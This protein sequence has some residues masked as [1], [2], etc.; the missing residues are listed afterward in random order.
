MNATKE[1]NH[2]TDLVHTQP[3]CRAVYV[4]IFAVMQLVYEVL[5]RFLDLPDFQPNIA[6]KYIHQ[7]FIV[8]VVSRE[9][10][11]WESSY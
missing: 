3:G 7:R 9:L 8:Q 11:L 4:W 2:L 5:L 10:N 6:K 1:I